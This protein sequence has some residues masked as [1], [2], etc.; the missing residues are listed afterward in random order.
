MRTLKIAL[1]G[2]ALTP[3]VHAAEL[4]LNLSD[5]TF[6]ARYS[7]SLTNR[8]AAVDLGWLHHVDNGDIV[9]AS[10]LV[11]QSAGNGDSYALGGQ[12]VTIL[13]DVDDA[14][15]I[16]LGG[17]FNVGLPMQPKLRV[18]GHAWFAPKVTS[19]NDADGYQDLGVR[20]G[21]QALERGEIYL[22]YRYTEVGYEEHPDLAVSDN[23][24]IGMSL[25][26]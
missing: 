24:Q 6:G 25:K 22:G 21:Y 26:F 1:L 14:Y 8:G 17:R 9:N 5:E 12:A 15:A 3:L 4:D 13:N 20:V 7:T 18:A 19:F 11:E 23:V 10:L 16:A 2:L